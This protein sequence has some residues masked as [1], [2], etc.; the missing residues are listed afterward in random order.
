MCFSCGN[1]SFETTDDQQSRIQC[2]YTCANMLRL[3]L[4]FDQRMSSDPTIFKMPHRTIIPVYLPS[5]AFITAPA[6]GP[7]ASTLYHRL[8]RMNFDVPVILKD[9]RKGRNAI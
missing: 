7:P 6:A 4:Y 5:S 9:L 1:L 8:V 3:T 2:I